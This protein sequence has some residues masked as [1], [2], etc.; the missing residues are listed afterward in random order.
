M[1]SSG[2][3]AGDSGRKNDIKARVQATCPSVVGKN[4]EWN[5]DLKQVDGYTEL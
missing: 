4:P 1:L 3:H 5:Y 2:K